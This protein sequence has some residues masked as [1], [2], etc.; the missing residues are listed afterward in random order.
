MNLTVLDKSCFWL[1]WNQRLISRAVDSKWGSTLVDRILDELDGKTTIRWGLIWRKVLLL[2]DYQMLWERRKVDR[3]YDRSIDRPKSDRLPLIKNVYTMNEQ[4][5]LYICTRDCNTKYV[6]S[7]VYILVLQS[8]H[9]ATS[10]HCCYCCQCYYCH[11]NCCCHCHCCY[12][13]CHY[14]WCH[15]CSFITAVPLLLL[16]LLPITYFVTA[17]TLAIGGLLTFI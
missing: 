15:W 14:Y 16:L 7:L 12:C 4:H 8:K 13:Y 6:Q 10:C 17:T 5:M 11:C 3:K 9:A 1:I 2:V